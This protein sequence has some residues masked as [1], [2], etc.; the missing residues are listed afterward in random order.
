M[1]GL[2]TLAYAAAVVI[3]SGILAILIGLMTWMVM[4]ERQDDGS[5]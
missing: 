2:E 4:L 3:G 1:T 5:E